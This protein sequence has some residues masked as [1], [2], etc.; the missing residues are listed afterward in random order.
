ML[1]RSN[2]RREFC[3]R[4]RRHGEGAPAADTALDP[5]RDVLFVILTSHGSPEGIAEKG[6][7]V[8]GILPPQTL[9]GMLAR[10]RSGTRC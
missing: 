6:G 4:S 10:A 2:S 7:A 9:A 5:E 3:G 1:V 8:E